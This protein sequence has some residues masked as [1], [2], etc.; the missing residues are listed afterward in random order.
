MHSRFRSSLAISICLTRAEPNRCGLTGG[1]CF[2]FEVH[3]AQFDLTKRVTESEQWNPARDT[4]VLT[5]EQ[6]DGR[7]RSPSVF[8]GN[9]MTN[10]TTED[11]TTASRRRSDSQDVSDATA[12]GNDWAS[13]PEEDL[14]AEFRPNIYFKLAAAVSALF[15]I[16]IL[17]FVA[18]IFGDPNAP[19]AQFFN[20]HGGLVLMGEVVVAVTLGFMAMAAD[21]R[22]IRTRVAE[23]ERLAAKQ[24]ANLTV[25][26]EQ[27]ASNPDGLPDPESTEPAT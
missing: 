7:Q 1:R 20:R 3:V 27:P 13:N 4:D 18:N 19:P 14:Y 17:A 24:L 9:S 23:R 16:T 15:V 21:R 11:S 12:S 5:A 22:D 26:L 2:G 8:P 6:Y 10:N 25:D